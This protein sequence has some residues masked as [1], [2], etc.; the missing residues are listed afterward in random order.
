M[1]IYLDSPDER[2]AH[3]V[4]FKYLLAMGQP[5]EAIL[6]NIMGGKPTAVYLPLARKYLELIN[7][8][9]KELT[10]EQNE[11]KMLAIVEKTMKEKDREQEIT[12]DPEAFSDIYA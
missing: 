12:F 11:E 1:L 6:R 3:I 5:K 7:V 2:L 10:E 8:A 4:Q 9:E